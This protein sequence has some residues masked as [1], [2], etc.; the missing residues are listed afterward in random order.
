MPTLELSIDATGAQR[1]ANDAA[2]AI[3]QVAGRAKSATQAVG[4]LGTAAKVGGNNLSAAFA[5]TGGGLSV[6]RGLV[7][8]GD[9]LRSANV[10]MATFSASQALLDLG[11]F[12]ADMRAVGAA[13][14][15]TG[16]AMSTLAAIVKANPLLTIA[17]VLA[18]AATAMG[19]FGRETKKVTSEWDKLGKAVRD[20]R[21]GSQVKD[22]LG[23]QNDRGSELSSLESLIQGYL[24]Q[25]NYRMVST[26]SLRE[27]TGLPQ[28][29]IEYAAK[30]GDSNSRFINFEPGV[31][32][33]IPSIAAAA[34]LRRVYQ[35]IKDQVARQAPE[36]RSV[37]FEGGL[38]GS[39][40]GG[41]PNFDAGPRNFRDIENQ[42]LQDF[43]DQQIQK[44]A[45]GPG[46]VPGGV[47]FARINNEYSGQ[48]L[49]N[50]ESQFIAGQ[51]DARQRNIEQAQIEMDRLIQQG[52]QFGAT[53]G[54]A[55]FNV[56]SGAQT[57]RQAIAAIVSDLARATAQRGFAGIFGSVAGSFGKTGVQAAGDSSPGNGSNLTLPD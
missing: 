16:G 46:E 33:K 8:I 13:T 2:K 36:P 57:A 7:G 20:A 11:R 17:T 15:A 55:F 53:I 49:R 5:A 24:N 14:G 51:A 47:N 1:G 19:L 6:T 30:R 54:D 44:N 50:Q 48:F 56:A 26:S 28:S 22:Y 40:F 3:D 52:E 27:Q 9:G 4:Q 23:I 39:Q 18:G 29:Q 41:V 32:T 43:R 38:F 25:P 35:D 12:S 31:D 10:A 21:L 34:I 42:R 45:L 37:A